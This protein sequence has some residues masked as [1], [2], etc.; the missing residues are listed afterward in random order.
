MFLQVIGRVCAAIEIV[1]FVRPDQMAP[2]T[3]EPSGAELAAFCGTPVT[4]K[5]I[6]LNLAARSWWQ[7]GLAVF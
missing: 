4:V 6:A 1:H 5:R 2:G 7:S 3:P